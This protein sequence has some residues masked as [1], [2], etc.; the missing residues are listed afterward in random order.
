MP[1]GENQKAVARRNA[2]FSR[3]KEA[4]ELLKQE[5]ES[6]LKMYMQTIQDARAAH[7]YETAAKALQWLIEHFPEDEGVRILDASVDK[8]K[9]EEGPKGPQIQIGI[10]LGG[11]TPQRQIEAPVIDVNIDDEQ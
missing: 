3:V 10:A 9:V 6:I 2:L 1:T 4:R 8:T 7:D 5:A 11:I